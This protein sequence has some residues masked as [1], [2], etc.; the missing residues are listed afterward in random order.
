[1]IIDTKSGKKYIRKAWTG[2]NIPP[3]PFCK[4]SPDFCEI[5]SFLFQDQVKDSG[6]LDL[7]SCAGTSALD[8]ARIFWG[9]ATLDAWA[10][11]HVR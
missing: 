3:K 11:L 4:I 8:R 10:T 2:G 9:R 1:M 5:R 7:W 6:G